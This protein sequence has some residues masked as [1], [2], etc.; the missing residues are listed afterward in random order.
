MTPIRVLVADDEP[1]SRDCVTLELNRHHDVVVVAEC[2][3]GREAVEAIH[4]LDPDL[5]FLDI[6]MPD[7]D[8]FDVVR[9]VGAEAMP[10]V[11]FITAYDEHAL[12]AFRLHALDYILKPF[13]TTRFSEA[14]AHARAQ[15]RLRHDGDLGRRLASMVQ[16]LHDPLADPDRSPIPHQPTY[17]S[18]LLVRRDGHSAFVPVAD[19]RWFAAERNYVRIHHAE[20]E[21]TMRSTLDDLAERLDPARFVRI[22]RSTVVNIERVRE[23]RPW[24][25]GD[26]VAILDTGEELRVS[27][28]FK[29]SLTTPVR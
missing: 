3:D 16:S 1:L 28:T 4:R 26:G 10:P 13:D 20:G 5:V 7:M 18:R 19:V 12:R 15:L 27:R 24:F 22:H 11:V 23:V 29:P 17:A 14:L 6:R 25:G 2:G 8:G 21:D 9:S